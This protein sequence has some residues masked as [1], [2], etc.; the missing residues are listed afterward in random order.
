MDAD[1]LTADFIKS[2]VDY[3]IKMDCLIKVFVECVNELN[4]DFNK[5]IAEVKNGVEK[6]TLQ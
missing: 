4:K 3:N 2:L 5:A 1:K 6:T